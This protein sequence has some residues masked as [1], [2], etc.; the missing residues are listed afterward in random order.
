MIGS[1]RTALALLLIC[2][3][4][5]VLAPLQYIVLKTKLFSRGV[6]PRLWHRLMT[7]AL[8]LRIHVSGNMVD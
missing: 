6:M 4:T 3:A 2:G 8:G 1:I 5:L 7:K